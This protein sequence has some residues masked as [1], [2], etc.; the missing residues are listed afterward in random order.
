[1]GAFREKPTACDRA[2]A[3]HPLPETLAPP[4]LGGRLVE[5]L[6]WENLGWENLGRAGQTEVGS[7]R[8]VAHG[9]GLGS[10][11]GSGRGL[12]GVW[13]GSGRGLVGL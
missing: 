10:G 2:R 8:P 5:N 7:D 4:P 6:G 9:S 1:M 13:P 3:P 11:L 12:A